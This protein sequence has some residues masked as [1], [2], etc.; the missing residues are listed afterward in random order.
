MG[1]YAPGVT[2]EQRWVCYGVALVFTTFYWIFGRVIILAVRSRLPEPEQVV[3][4]MVWTLPLAAGMTFA[5]TVGVGS[6]LRYLG[7]GLDEMVPSFTFKLLM[8][9]TLVMSIM[10]IYEI[11]YFGAKYKQANL[12]RESLARRNSQSQLAALRRQMNPHFLFNSLNTLANVIPEDSRKATLFTQRLSAVYRRILEW[13][14]REIIPLGEE[15]TALRDY[16]FLLQTRFED[17]LTVAWSLD[18]MLVNKDDGPPE[19]S[20][21]IGGRGARVH[22]PRW[23]VGGDEEQWWNELPAVLRHRYVVPLSL[24]LLVENAVKHNVVS[25][26]H[27]LRI[28]VHFGPDYVTVRNALRRRARREASTGWGLDNLKTQYALLSE[29]EV[30]VYQTDEYFAVGIPL[31]DEPSV[32]KRLSRLAETV[33]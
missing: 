26:A 21:S 20:E 3:R 31:L 30:R 17:K 15:V 29:R 4:R 23:G 22:P 13:R 25:H 32:E 2:G 16:V 7:V 9:F 6:M 8:A 28:D 19:I 11:I 24:Q 14:H 1:G 27:P 12:D 18:E 5:V 10:F 33:N